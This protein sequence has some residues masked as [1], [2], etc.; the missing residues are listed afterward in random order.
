MCA[1]TLKP[2]MRFVMSR[3]CNVHDRM[4]PM[5]FD[6]PRRP[7][8]SPRLV[9][10]FALLGSFG[11]VLVF[12]L[13]L[14]H[15]P[16]GPLGML[17]VVGLVLLGGVLALVLRSAVSPEQPRAKRLAL[18]GALAVVT[19]GLWLPTYAW[20]EQGHEPWAWVA[21]FTIGAC[22]LSV[23]RAGVIVAVG[24]AGMAGIGAVMFDGSV[25]ENIGYALGSG[26]LI[27]L[28]GLLLVWLLR[29]VWAAE[30]GRDAESDLVLAHERLRMSRELHD[31]LGHRLGIIALKAELALISPPPIRLA[32]LRRAGKSAK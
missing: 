24:L 32:L 8:V 11:W 18:I 9:V 6:A 30:A 14:T 19:L 10:L 22:A 31:V 2:H 7:P 17:Y 1:G 13:R 5:S 28:S 29:L 12:P 3:P 4:G 21:G 25:V 15:P 27:W 20:A 16:S 23:P 26:A